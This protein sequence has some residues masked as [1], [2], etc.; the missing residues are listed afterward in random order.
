MVQLYHIYIDYYIETPDY[1]LIVMYLDVYL[2]IL[3]YID[4]NIQCIMLQHLHIY[5]GFHIN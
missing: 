5:F 4:L 3:T 2:L 1:S